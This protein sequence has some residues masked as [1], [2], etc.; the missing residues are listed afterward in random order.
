LG[1]LNQKQIE[2]L[3][4]PGTYED[5]DGLRLLIKPSGKKYWVLRFQLAGKRREM[6]LGSYPKLGLKD[7]RLDA[8]DK[9]RLLQNGIDP[10]TSRDAEREAQ[11]VA[12]QNHKCKSVTFR[13][14]A[15][16][17]ITSHRAGWKN[18]KHGQQWKN[19]LATY[20]E[21]IIGDLAADAITTDHLLKILTP[22]WSS[23]AETASRVRNRIELVLDAAKARGLREG[24]NPA[25]WR[26][27]LDKLLPANSK[28]K[29]IRNQ[30]ALPHA[31]LTEF[32]RAL[33]NI[34]GLS[35]IALK[36]TILTACRTSEVLQADWREIDLETKLW[37]I[38]AIRMKA[39]RTHVVPLSD[40]VV[41]LL[42]SLP[43]VTDSTLVFPGARQGRP[44]SN[45]AMLMTLRRMDVKST[46]ESG[47]GW[48]DKD[49]RVITAHGF[50]STFRDWAAECTH[51][52]REVCEMALAHVVAT[53]AEAAYWRSDLLQKRRTLMNDWA[54]FVTST[55]NEKEV[56][57]AK[58][59]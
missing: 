47:K 39:D 24:E 54:A 12:Q 38:P 45:M 41:A 55:P 29:R 59:A 32:I 21:P 5:G 4:A 33:N 40:T 22:I 28:T 3:N 30:P 2:H 35:A 34:E 26:G 53:G 14:I 20:A 18:I 10:I 56:V 15:S 8:S 52:T 31:E 9:R 36:M 46:D 25:R 42:A 50:R 44:I 13:E 57:L 27:H 7:A 37:T 23:K 43:R 58:Q 19:T 48:R 11:K 1:K 51:H 16:D 6:G 49:G 17:Y